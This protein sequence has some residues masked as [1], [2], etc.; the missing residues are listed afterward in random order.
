MRHAAEATRN[1]TYAALASQAKA[2]PMKPYYTH[3]FDAFYE[4][5][6]CLGRKAFMTASLV[7]R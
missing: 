6:F 4:L 3:L 7:S 5:G 1:S 2:L